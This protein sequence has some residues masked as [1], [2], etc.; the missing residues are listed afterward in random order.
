MPAMVRN[1]RARKRGRERI[2]VTS[3][4]KLAALIQDGSV[5][6]WLRD[7]V[8]SKREEILAALAQNRPYMITGPNHEE[9]V[10]RRAETAAAA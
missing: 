1:V 7:E 5:P 8:Q 2:M 3:L 4:S 9:I 10:I 6:A